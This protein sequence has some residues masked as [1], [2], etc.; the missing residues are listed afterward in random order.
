MIQLSKNQQRELVDSI[1]ASVKAF[2]PEWTAPE[3]SD[4]GITLIQLFVWLSER[5]Q[6]E[7]T[8]A[9]N[10]ATTVFRSLLEQLPP[11][12]SNN[13]HVDPVLTRP[14]Y[15]PRKLLTADDLQV[16]QDYFLAK[17]RRHNRF[18]FGS[19]IVTGLDVSIDDA[20]K[21]HIII[22]PGY[23]IGPTG[24]EILVCNPAQFSL[25]TCIVSGYVSLA[26]CE[27][28]IQVTSGEST[29]A[30]RIIEGFRIEFT[31]DVTPEDVA[32]ARV[33]YRR[34]KWTLDARFRPARAKCAL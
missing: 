24:D 4:P 27:Q 11:T 15:F 32:V 19:G 10:T 34:N 9:M 33:K 13:C 21:G 16:E 22:T 18:L 17:L 23:A 25:G 28:A 7:K 30:S 6:F 29:E 2:A 3:S 12:V 8:P 26:F 31:E 1:V 5:V 14:R 20:K